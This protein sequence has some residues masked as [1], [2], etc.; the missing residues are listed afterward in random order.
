MSHFLFY[1]LLLSFLLKS[2]FPEPGLCIIFQISIKKSSSYRS[3]R[4]FSTFS[5]NSGSSSFPCLLWNS[6]WSNFK[7]GRYCPSFDEPA[8]LHPML[9][10]AL[11]QVCLTLA[12]L[13]SWRVGSVSTFAFFY[14]IYIYFHFH[15]GQINLIYKILL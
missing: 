11:T 9:R 2:Y 5:I 1:L 14:K 10:P 7:N 12:S 4:H 6:L 8:T 13:G 3:M 15:I